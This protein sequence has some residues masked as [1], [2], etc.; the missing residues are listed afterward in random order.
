M[1]DIRNKPPNAGTMPSET[2]GGWKARGPI[3]GGSPALC[4]VK[5]ETDRLEVC[6]TFRTK[7]CHVGCRFYNRAGGN[8]RNN[9]RAYAEIRGT[10]GGT[11][12]VLFRVFTGIS[13]YFRITGNKIIRI[14]NEA[15]GS[16]DQSCP[17]PEKNYSD[18]LFLTRCGR[19]V[20][21]GQDKRQVVAV[22]K[23]ASFR[24]RM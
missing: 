19:R 20:K 1:K 18:F 24:Q 2:A 12:S 22:Q 11:E 15:R 9:R 4:A 21:V 10:L 17:A 7:S 23:V 14:A 8:R 5:M 13:A 16:G 3:G 6:P